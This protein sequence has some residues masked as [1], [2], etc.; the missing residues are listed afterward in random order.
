[1][2]SIKSIVGVDIEYLFVYGEHGWYLKIDTVE[3]LTDYH[4]KMDS[5]KFEAALQMYMQKVDP[6]NMPLEKRIKL[7]ESRDFK[8]LQAAMI[9]ARKINGTILEGFRCPNMEIGMTELRCIREHGAVYI[10]RAGGHTYDLPYTQFCRRKEL[11]FPDFRL[12]D[13]RIKKYPGGVH[14]YAFIGDMQVKNGED[15]KW[16]SSEAA[17]NAAK[18]IVLGV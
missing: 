2:S 17:Q 5:N 1:M 10:N 11:V 12:S 8:F 14:W 18:D 15:I 16:N 4:K 13:I 3:K 6:E 9:Q 7:M